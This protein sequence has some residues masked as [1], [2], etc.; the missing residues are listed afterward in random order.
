MTYQP[1][2]LI[3]YHADCIDG[4]T[5]A[6][7]AHL[8]SPEAELVPADYG[9]APPDVTGKRVLIVDFSYPRDV[10]L[11]MSERA[12]FILV[13][14]HHKH[15]REDLEG[16]SFCIFDMERSGA[17]LAWDELHGPKPR[18]EIIGH[19]EDR[20]LWRFHLCGTAEVHAALLLRE[21]T[22]A[23]WTRLMNEGPAVL[24]HDGELIRAFIDKLTKQLAEK[25]YFIDWGG[26]IFLATNVPR[27]LGSDTAE[28]LKK[29]A[30][31]YPVLLWRWEGS[32]YRFE[33]RSGPDGPDVS[34]IAKQ[35]G[36]GGH[37]HA[38]GFRAS[39]APEPVHQ[40]SSRRLQVLGLSLPADE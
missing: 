17:G 35:F 23:E 19:V 37:F 21:R 16:L 24:T 13:L 30:G 6:W 33:L 20:D 10:L 22:L 18:P 3:I 28:Q 14:D 1:F 31:K 39:A 4:F 27:E 34:E 40:L 11:R 36:G 5:A 25:A 32:D 26:Y 8:H 9:D 7:A 2:D 15:A 29:R 38:A 12:E